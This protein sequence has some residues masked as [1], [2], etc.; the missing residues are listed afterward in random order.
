MTVATE[1]MTS[2]SVR[3]EAAVVRFMG[4]TPPRALALPLGVSLLLVAFGLL[5][6]ARENSRLLWA[7]V[8]AG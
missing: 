7:F 8:G 6:S 4:L 3:S 5:P 2:A 1:T